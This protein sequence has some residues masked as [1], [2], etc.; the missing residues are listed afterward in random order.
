MTSLTVL[1][2]REGDRLIVTG[3]HAAAKAKYLAISR[4]IVGPDMLLPSS[5]VVSPLYISLDNAARATLMGCCL[6]MA[7]CLLHEQQI[8][9][10][11]PSGTWALTTV[12]PMTPALGRIA[13][14]SKMAELYRSLHPN[15]QTTMSSDTQSTS[16][17]M[18]GSWTKLSVAKTGGPTEGRESFACFI[19]KGRMYVCGGRKASNGPWCRDLWVLDLAK[20]DAWRQLPKYPISEMSTGHF[21][22]RTM[23][24]HKDRA[25]LFTGR[26]TLDVFDLVKEKWTTLVTTYKPTR[27][28]IQVAGVQDGWPYPGRT[29]C[30]AAMQI[31]GDKLYVFGGQHGRTAVGCNLFMVLDLTTLK[32]R[33]LTGYVRA[34]VYADYT[35]PGPR[36]N[37]A[38][39]VSPDQTRIYV[40]FGH[41]DQEVA[42]RHDEPHGGSRAFGYRDMWTWSIG[43]EKWRQERMPGNAPCSRTELAYTFNPKL[44]KATVFGGYHPCLPTDVIDG[45]ESKKFE[46][47]YFADTFVYHMGSNVGPTGDNSANALVQPTLLAP[48]WKQVL[49]HGF[50]TH[51]CQA[52]LAC[53]PDSGRT[54][55]FGGC[56]GD[57][58]ELK[59]DDESGEGHFDAVDTENEARSARAG[60]WQRCFVCGGAGP[61]RKCGAGYRGAHNTRRT[62]TA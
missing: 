4:E 60:P 17:Q 35:C 53:D 30:D 46:Y 38:S 3:Q 18:R 32:W 31:V 59:L 7:R 28:D 52:Q 13:N 51:R 34:P 36:K 49:T 21:V 61:W 25:I 12:H 62:G 48:K 24:V 58:W 8:E 11:R 56:F 37:A 50:P 26:P 41:A 55:L 14:R 2:S 16:L 39:W 33:R 9:A 5:A 20:H 19:W 42:E 54:Y 45:Q 15:P 43:E 57:L 29:L 1:S 23:V 6:G 40:L 47:T 22:G 44:Q 10:Q 27:D